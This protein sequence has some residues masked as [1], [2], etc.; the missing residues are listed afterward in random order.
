MREDTVG[1]IHILRNPVDVLESN[2][3]FFAR[4][5]I[6]ADGSVPTAAA[7]R[8]WVAR[9]IERGGAEAWQREG[10]GTWEQNAASWIESVLPFARLT[11]RYEAMKADTHAAAD[12]I[13]RFLRIDRDAV[14][15][16]EAVER[17]SAARLRAMEDAEVAARQ[18]GIF[19]SPQF[20]DS[21]T[22][23]RRFIGGGGAGSAFRLTDDE[24]ARANASF[25]QAM[26]RFGYAPA[27][28]GASS[29]R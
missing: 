5:E 28:S 14:A 8:Q 4:T 16:A 10:F 15:I 9:Y 18:P 22:A 2:L 29:P 20:Q 13:C 6:G 25:A 24:R 12:A 11:L 1:V 7:A 26:R 3:R 23:D 21:A 19:Y 17:S 27:A